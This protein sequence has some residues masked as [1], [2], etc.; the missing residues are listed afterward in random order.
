M[1]TATVLP[2][3]DNQARVAR[4]H[5]PHTF[6]IVTAKDAQKARGNLALRS[7]PFAD[8]SDVPSVFTNASFCTKST[9]SRLYPGNLGPFLLR[10]TSSRFLARCFFDFF[11]FAPRFF[12][13][14]SSAFVLPRPRQKQPTPGLKP[15]PCPKLRTP[16]KRRK[17][18]RPPLRAD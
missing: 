12:S 7:S 15:V 18:S 14:I 9:S 4:S 13:S 6:P 11:D 8:F 2:R 10:R 16:K 5:A 1:T 3:Q 17:H